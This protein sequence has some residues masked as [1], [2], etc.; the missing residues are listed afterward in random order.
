M[1]VLNS[2][3]ITIWG[4]Q[5]PW[6]KREKRAAGIGNEPPAKFTKAI[7][8]HNCRMTRFLR[9]CGDAGLTMGQVAAL[10]D[11]DDAEAKEAP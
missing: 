11:E 1:T 8:R 3:T 4:W 2:V 6:C 10:L 9:A 7:D 5:C